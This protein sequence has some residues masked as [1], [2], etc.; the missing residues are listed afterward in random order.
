[1]QRKNEGFRGKS[2]GL[3]GRVK[4]EPLDG[5]LKRRSGVL[6]RE[7]GRGGRGASKKGRE[8]ETAVQILYIICKYSV[9]LPGFT[10]SLI[11]QSLASISQSILLYIMSCT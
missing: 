2:G 4:G 10:S 8:D 11:K 5:R 6:K 3:E 7:G 9:C 1:V